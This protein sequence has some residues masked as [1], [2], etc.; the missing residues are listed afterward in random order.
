MTSLLLDTENLAVED[1]REAVRET[2]AVRPVPMHASFH[3]LDESVQARIEGWTIGPLGV[4]RVFAR[5]LRLERTKRHAASG[6]CG[7]VVGGLFAQGEGDW[8]IGERSGLRDQV[9]LIDLAEP[10][11]LTWV[12]E[13]V[14]HMFEIPEERLGLA[15]SVVRRSAARLTSSALYPVVSG[16]LR[17]FISGVDGVAGEPNGPALGTATVQ[18]LRALIASAADDGSAGE[19]TAEVLWPLILAY[20]DTH[21]AEPD[22]SPTGIARANNVSVRYLYKL[23][24]QHNMRIAEW[25]VDRRLHGARQELQAQSVRTVAEIARRWGFTDPA[26]FSG[27]FRD[28]FG[29]SPRECRNEAR[30]RLLEASSAQ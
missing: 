12:G 15:P 27:R 19:S 20:V 30:A 8:Q 11:A 22:L 10:T 1:R 18:M 14:A 24:A 21:L 4:L 25:I 28:A 5:D 13:G 9:N 23:S 3:C 26:H 16:H 6:T 7:L 2:F 29:M 17:Q